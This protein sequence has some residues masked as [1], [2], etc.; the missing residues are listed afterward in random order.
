MAKYLRDGKLIHS[1]EKNDCTVHALAETM[2]CSYLEAYNLCEL[3]G[4]QP[5]RG[6]YSDKLIALVNKLHPNT[7]QRIPGPI[8]NWYKITLNQFCQQYPI[9]RFFVCIRGHALTVQNGE[10]VD[11]T[12]KWRYPK[13]IVLQAWAVQSTFQGNLQDILNRTD[14]PKF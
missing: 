8:Q 14:Y 5:N 10:I 11:T 6:H 12:T 13:S 1:A 4:R 7:F 2:Q 3:S 9:G